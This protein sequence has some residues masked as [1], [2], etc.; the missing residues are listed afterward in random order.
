MNETE[1]LKSVHT[2]KIGFADLYFF[3][4]EYVFQLGEKEISIGFTKR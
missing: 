2:D 1:Q 3:V 4:P